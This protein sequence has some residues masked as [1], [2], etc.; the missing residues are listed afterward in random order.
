VVLSRRMRPRRS[1][2][3]LAVV[4]WVNVVALLAPTVASSDA[5]SSF[6]RELLSKHALH[7]ETACGRSPEIGDGTRLVFARGV[8][9]KG[10]R[11]ARGS[12]ALGIISARL[13]YPQVLGWTCSSFETQDAELL[14]YHGHD[15]TASIKQLRA[16]LRETHIRAVLP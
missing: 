11:H 8:S 9:C 4:L 13:G 16:A 3:T 10:Q 2:T 1:A 5:T 7:G 15:R 12:S 14:C 6:F